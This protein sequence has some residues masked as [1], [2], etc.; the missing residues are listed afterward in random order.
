MK[1]DII[2]L[3]P[4]MF[5]GPFDESIVS[6]AKRDGQIEIAVHDLR[7]WGQD[8]RKT[9]DGRPYGGGVGMILLIEPIAKALK[10]LKTKDTKVILL[11]PRGVTF[12]QAKARDLSNEK[13]LILIAGH[14]EGL[15][16][17]ITEHLIDEEISVGDY[18]L[19]GGEIPAM[20]VVDAITR[21]LPGVLK[22]ETATEIESFSEENLLEYPQYTRP[23]D[24]EGWKVPEVLLSGNHAEIDKWR[25]EEAKKK[26][27]LVRPDLNPEK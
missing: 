24:F 16:E 15:D 19:T 14:Y 20:I 25:K 11:S 1:I 10:E 23:E 18:V 12:N 22:K 26:T 9:V 13:H 6:R 21:L 3:F 7:K 5:A 2:T 17:R 4:K 8:E 27:A